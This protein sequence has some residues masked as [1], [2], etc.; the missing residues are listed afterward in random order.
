MYHLRAKYIPALSFIR[1]QPHLSWGTGRTLKYC[2]T[3]VVQSKIDYEVQIYGTAKSESQQLQDL[4]QNECL[5]VCTGSIR[6]SPA[7]S[8]F[9][10]EIILW[11][12]YEIMD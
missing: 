6:S 9:T 2:Y 12:K 7:E 5:G 3:A 1:H 8:M 10:Q 11:L 4:K